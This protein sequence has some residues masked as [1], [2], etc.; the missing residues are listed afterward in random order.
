MD[1]KKL[2]NP[3]WKRSDNLR[4]PSVWKSADGYHLFYSRYSNNDWTK[5]ENWSIAHVITKDFVTFEEDRDISAKGFAS[6]GDVIRWK[7]KYILPYQSYPEVPTMLCYSTSDDLENWSKP[8]FF[9]EEAVHLPWNQANRVIDPTFVT[10]GERLHCFFVG[11]DRVHYASATN[12][13]GHAYTDDPELKEWTITTVDSPLIGTC[14]DGPDGAENVT[15]FRNNNE[16]VMIY[17][18]GLKSQHLAYITSKD[19]IHWGNKGKTT[20]PEQS[21][22]STRYGAPY[23]WKEDEYWVMILMGEDGNSHTTFGLLTSKDGIIWEALS[24]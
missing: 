17:S 13:V 21:W 16:W 5:P 18:E 2:S 14:E 10:E 22:M 8:V 24:E 19:L 15:V 23:V 7:G 3:I 6:P 12:L 9:L 20:I 11:T 1:L 4:D